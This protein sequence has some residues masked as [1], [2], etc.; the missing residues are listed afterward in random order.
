MRTI[1]RYLA[2][3]FSATN[4]K[5]LLLTSLL[6]AAAI[7]LN[8]YFGV[9]DSI[10]KL[11]AISKTGAWYLV[12]A[13]AFFIPYGLGFLFSGSLPKSRE[14][15]MLLIVAPAVFAWKMS[16]PVQLSLPGTEIENSYWNK[17]VYWPFKL[18]VVSLSVYIIWRLM[19]EEQPLYG[20]DYKRLTLKPY[21]IMLLIMLPLIALASTQSDFLLV[22]PKLQN[23]SIPAIPKSQIAYKLLYELSYGSDFFTIEFFFRGFL[24][25]AFIKWVGPAAILPMAA[26]YCTIHFGKPLAECISSYFGGILLGVITYNTGSIYGGLMVHL[27]IAWLMELGGFLGNSISWF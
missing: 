11:P 3:Y 13:A 10:S 26:F 18:A 21:A 22:Y 1:L 23:V 15:Y 5:C 25:L 19:K 27:G 6:I 2:N 14:F 16:A 24:V 20:M 12:F 7:F 4:K 8:Y 9:E 17:V